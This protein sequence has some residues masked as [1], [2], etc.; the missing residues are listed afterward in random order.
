M[1]EGFDEATVSAGGL[2]LMVRRGGAGPAVLLLHGHPRTSATWHRV[3]PQ[4][5]D[6]GH[7]VV[8]ADLPGYGRSAQPPVTLDHRS[9]SKRAFAHHLRAG[10][11][12]MGIEHFAVVGHDRG[13]YVALRLALDHPGT[14]TQ[15]V[16]MDCLP[17]SEHLNRM[18]ERFALAWWHWFFYA[19]P[20]IP[21][22]VIGAD[23]DAWYAG[24]RDAMGADN[25]DEFRAATR[26]PEVVRAMLEDYR[27]GVS[28]DVEDERA[29]R[30]AG[31]RV[32]QPLLLLWSLRDDLYRL[33]GDPLDIW[34]T[35][36]RTVSGRGIDSGH[37]MAEEAPDELAAELAAFL[38]PSSPAGGSGAC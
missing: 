16:L 4:L 31:R 19:Q 12:T 26:R 25:H 35:W 10:M 15:V 14:V 9:H 33:H 37:H 34:R 5:V 24:D 17:I 28:V 21:E 7:T 1:F 38:S 36:A 8:C 13:S 3:A 30:A 27:A 2:E 32:Q 18:D 6:A 29:D 20:E 23:P 22:R 11:H